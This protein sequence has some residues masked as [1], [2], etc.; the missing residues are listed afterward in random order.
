MLLMETPIEIPRNRQG[1]ALEFRYTPQS[2]EL[3]DITSCIASVF[4]PIHE[5]FKQALQITQ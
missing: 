5:D 2:K 3:K 1:I 4:K